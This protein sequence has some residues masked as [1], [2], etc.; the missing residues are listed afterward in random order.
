V[1]WYFYDYFSTHAQYHLSHSFLSWIF[2]SPY[3][4]DAPLLIGAVYFHQG[5]DANTSFWADAFA[6]FGFAGIVIFTVVCGLVLLGIDAV[7]RGRDARIAG[8]MLAI[9][10]LSLGSTGLFT[11]LLTQGLALGGVLLVLMPPGSDP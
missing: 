6:N 10:G 8:P 2:S 7:G 4:V 1:G 5:T 11:T 3:S 9:A